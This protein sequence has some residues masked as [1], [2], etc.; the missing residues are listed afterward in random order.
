MKMFSVVP[1]RKWRKLT[2]KPANERYICKVKNNADRGLR[3]ETE[4]CVYAC[5]DLQGVVCKWALRV[6]GYFRG[7]WNDVGTA[8]RIA[9]IEIYCMSMPDLQTAKAVSL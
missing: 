1:K 5:G 4:Y 3:G 2:S 6:D 8:K 7:W 9:E